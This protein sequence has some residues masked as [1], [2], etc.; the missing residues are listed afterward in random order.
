MAVPARP[1][2]HTTFLKAPSNVSS[3]FADLLGDNE[4]ARSGAW[5]AEGE[6]LLIIVKNNEK[7]IEAYIPEHEVKRVTVGAT[8]VFY[9]E[10]IDE[11]P[12]QGTIES[13]D[14]IAIRNLDNAY[15]ATRYDG[16]IAV[17]EAESG[18]MF[19]KTAHY[20]ARIATTE[21]GP[22]ITRISRGTVAINAEKK[23][24]AVRAWKTILAIIVRESGF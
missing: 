6:P 15:L 11:P 20:R 1:P 3:L 7:V 13:I 16:G 4:D 21:S 10:N 14:Q 23:S 22:P 24:L 5:I 9:P 18:Q 2:V 12:I 19:P 17:T 8:A